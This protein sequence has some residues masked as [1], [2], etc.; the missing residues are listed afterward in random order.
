MVFYR[1]DA[2]E[3]LENWILAKN[4]EVRQ[5]VESR[6]NSWIIWYKKKFTEKEQVIREKF[7]A[8]LSKIKTS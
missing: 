8:K 4:E 2:L 5:K 3:Q 6:L 1:Y 7:R